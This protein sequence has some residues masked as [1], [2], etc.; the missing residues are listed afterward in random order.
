MIRK[1]K[2]GEIP[3]SIDFGSLISSVTIGSPKLVALF[4]ENFYETICGD[5]AKRLGAWLLE[6]AEFIE[7]GEQS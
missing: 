4:G 2:V 1:L 5:Q 7:E 3:E 6:V